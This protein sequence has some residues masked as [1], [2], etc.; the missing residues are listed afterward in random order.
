M[1][2]EL[3]LSKLEE[4]PSP[5]IQPLSKALVIGPSFRSRI[6]HSHL[7]HQSMLRP[8]IFLFFG[9]F[10]ALILLGNKNGR[11]SQA[12]RGNTG[13]PGD[14]TQG[15]QPKTCIACHNQGPIQASLAISVLDSASNPVTQYLPGKPYTARV[16]ITASG[17]GL[18]GYGFQMIGLR[19]SNNSDLDGFSDMN[20][21]NYKIAN[22]PGGRSYAEHDNI[23]SSNIFNV[24]WTAPSTGTGSVTLYAAGNGVNSNGGTGGD[25]AGFSSI[26]L[27][28]FISATGELAGH[29][30]KMTPIPNP[31]QSEA[32][33]NL[34]NLEAGEYGLSA[35]D[36]SGK[37]VWTSV[38]N[39][40]EGAANVNLPSLD[41]CP[42][43][44]FLRL[45]RGNR[46][47]SVKVLKL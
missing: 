37:R 1:A 27:T 5:S 35:F 8:I 21:N 13:A 29:L 6:S 20:P 7:S 26:K 18:N 12:Q 22:I 10:S 23:S 41:W 43:V 42:G 14:E 36:L 15:G 24:K 34:E 16:T 17:S 9:I 25:G 47:T 28:E 19:D 40:P 39:L 46:A 44:Y 3:N 31:V 11:A 4:K 38:Q 2:Q 30:P 32:V 33:L 45:E